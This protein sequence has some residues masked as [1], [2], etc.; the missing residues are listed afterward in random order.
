MFE[1]ALL[2]FISLRLD[3]PVMEPETARSQSLTE[4]KVHGE[5]SMTKANRKSW[6]TRSETIVMVGILVVV[7]LTVVIGRIYG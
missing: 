7:V 4:V 1:I 3:R 5:T 6:P 2:I